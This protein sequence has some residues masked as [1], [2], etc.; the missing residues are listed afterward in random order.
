MLKLEVILAENDV[1]EISEGLKEI[2]VGGLTIIK[3]RGRGAKT[4]PEIH[5]SKG[6]EVFTP[7]F[8][9]KYRMMVVVPESK[10]EKTVD[11]IKKNARNGKIFISQMLRAIDIKSGNEG[12]EVI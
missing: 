9:D 4:E 6:M 7:H 8:G 5:T 12:E 2:D 3:V 10:E 1:M 11:I